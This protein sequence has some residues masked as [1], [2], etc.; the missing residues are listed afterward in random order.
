MPDGYE[1]WCTLLQ[2]Y[3]ADPT[4]ICSTSDISTGKNTEQLIPTVVGSTT[5]CMESIKD[6]VNTDHVY[7]KSTKPAAVCSTYM[8]DV[9]LIDNN[10][11]DTETANKVL[12][13]LLKATLNP[14]DSIDSS[15]DSLGSDGNRSPYSDSCTSALSPTDDEADWSDWN[16]PIDLQLFPQLC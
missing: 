4:I 11:M 13:E 8:D 15:Y 16:Q 1:E 10:A 2:Q 6:I 5:E 12:D 7:S 9:S 3:I 14:N